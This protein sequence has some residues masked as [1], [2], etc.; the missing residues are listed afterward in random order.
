MVSSYLKVTKYHARFLQ[1]HVWVHNFLWS[2]I[3][4]FEEQFQTLPMFSPT[5]T[6]IFLRNRSFYLEHPLDQHR[7][8]LVSFEK[9]L[10]QIQDF[11]FC[12]RPIA[13]LSQ[14]AQHLFLSLHDLYLLQ[15]KS[16]KWWLNPS[17]FLKDLPHAIRFN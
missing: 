12:L 3:K 4:T 2:P 11:K 17:R 5:P 10:I 7:F 14:S 15:F 9:Q 16:F 8:L 1:S 6:L 13:F